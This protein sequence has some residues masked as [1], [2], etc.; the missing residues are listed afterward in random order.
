MNLTSLNPEY[1]LAILFLGVCLITYLILPKIRKITLKLGFFDTPDGRSSHKDIVPT[2]GG[3]SFYIVLVLTLFCFQSFDQESVIISLLTSMS[4][5]FFTG[6]KDDFKDVSPRIKSLGQLVSVS[7]LMI[8]AEFRITSFHGFLGLHEL[9]PIISVAISLFLIIGLINAYNLIDGI[10][11]NASIVGIVIAT[12]L[13]VFFF[14]LGMYFYLAVCVAIVAML[15][16]FLRY[17]FSS[18]KKIFMGDTG[19]LLIGLTLGA[20]IMRLCSLEAVSVSLI[21]LSSSEILLFLLS[22]L[23][24][25]AF[26]ISRVIIIR[27][28]KKVPIFSPD[29]NHIHHVLIDTGLTHKEASIIVGFINILMISSMYVSLLYFGLF[30]STFVFLFLILTLTYFFFIIDKRFQTIKVKVKIRRILYRFT[31]KFSFKQT[32]T[33]FSKESRLAFNKKLKAIRILF[34]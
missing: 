26:D 27:L 28:M 29:R 4:I 17:N 9:H 1:Y 25:P 18:T 2:F 6:L 24:I 10:D 23:I 21:T 33:L 3:V 12:T 31:R 22:V 30:I 7:I 15:C 20:L 14:A 8:H 32:K 5:M 13:G 16:S 34:F 19:S 11:G